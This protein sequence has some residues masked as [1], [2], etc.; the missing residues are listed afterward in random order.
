M[1]NDELIITFPGWSLQIC[2]SKLSESAQRYYRNFI[3]NRYAGFVDSGSE[4]SSTIN[5]YATKRPPYLSVDAESLPVIIEPDGQRIKFISLYEKGWFDFDARYGELELCVP[6][7]I[8]QSATGCP[9]NFLRVLY[10][11]EC[12]EQR[13]ILM[14]AAGI[15]RNGSGY[16]FYGHSG[17]GKTTT[18]MLS[19]GVQILSDDLV[20]L[21]I[22]DERVVVQGVPFRGA[23]RTV[24]RPDGSAPLVGIFSLNKA[25]EHRIELMSSGTAIG[26]M[27][28][29]VPFVL[30][31]P[32][33]AFRVLAI[34][35]E[36][37]RR[38]PVR[39]LSFKQDPG[40]WEV[41]DAQDS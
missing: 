12:I 27:A 38:I 7:D 17:S 41:I 36:I 35:S 3:T 10:A 40:F 9:E 1:H 16:V 20:V 11:W 29:C 4:G 23:M 28:A 30:F 25:T 26:S 33:Q 31:T 15:I 39:R 24:P 18:T 14:H 21:R 19:P 32:Q 8:G 13:A 6:D 37:V 34:C 5:L 22:I 2:L